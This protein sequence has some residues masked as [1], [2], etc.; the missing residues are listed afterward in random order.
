[1]ISKDYRIIKKCIIFYCL[2]HSVVVLQTALFLTVA[3]DFFGTHPPASA[4]TEWFAL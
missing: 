1:M 3:I 2:F 4:Y